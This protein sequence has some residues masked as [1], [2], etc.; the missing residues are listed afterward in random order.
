ML[1]ANCGWNNGDWSCESLF[2]SYEWRIFFK[3]ITKLY[4]IHCSVLFNLY[5]SS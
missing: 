4:F 3:C 2:F 1:G 5:G